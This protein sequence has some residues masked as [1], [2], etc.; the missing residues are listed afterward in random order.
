MSP[1]QED[2]ITHKKMRLIS[3]DILV[4]QI[5]YLMI[6]LLRKMMTMSYLGSTIL[7][8]KSQASMSL[9]L[10]YGTIP[11]MSSRVYIQN[12][13]TAGHLVLGSMVEHLHTTYT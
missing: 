4:Q 9:I 5:C 11:Y 12:I 1:S 10:L 13:I 6:S 7:V 2:V 3:L 8:G